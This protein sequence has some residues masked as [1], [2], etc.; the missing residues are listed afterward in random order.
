ME[1]TETLKQEEISGHE[2]QVGLDTNTDRLIVSRNVTL[3]LR[4]GAVAVEMRT[5]N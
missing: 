3:T 1:M 4:T 2:P 5:K